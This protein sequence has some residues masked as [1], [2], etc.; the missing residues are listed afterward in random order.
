MLG[1]G[2]FPE[3]S[4]A[5]AR[6]RRDEARKLIAEGTDPSRKKREDKIAVAMAS[7]NTFGAIAAEHLQN[8]QEGGAASST[9]EK[10]RWLLQDL[11]APLAK[12]PVTEITGGKE[13][14]A[15]CC[16][17]SR[18][19]RRCFMITFNQMLLRFGLC[20]DG[21]RSQVPTESSLGALN[22]TV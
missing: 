14:F 6:E 7:Q 18:Q 21:L 20:A 19:A 9:L 16:C 10:N 5:T 22:T 3:I 17:R 15:L 2:S 1:L 4:L 11:A 8:L 13:S 12:R